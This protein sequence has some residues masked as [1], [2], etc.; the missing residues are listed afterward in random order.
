[1]L[2]SVVPIVWSY[3]ENSLQ[4]QYE[5]GNL[6]IT[7]C[8]INTMVSV[9]FYLNSTWCSPLNKLNIWGFGP[10]VISNRGSD[11]N[12]KPIWNSQLWFTILGMYLF[13]IEFCPCPS[14]HRV[15]FWKESSTINKSSR[16]NVV[17][18]VTSSEVL[19]TLSD[20]LL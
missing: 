20:M 13:P 17:T 6:F 12:P 10:M 4:A 7:F 1:M 11:K 19:R 9:N 5:K 18:Y 15:L 8:Y 14:S 16:F 3:P 2:K